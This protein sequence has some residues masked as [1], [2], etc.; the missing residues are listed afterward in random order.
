MIKGAHVLFYSENPEADRA[1]FRDVLGFSSSMWEAAGS[2]F[3]SHPQKP[4]STP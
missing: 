4:L 2:S 3:N 1:F